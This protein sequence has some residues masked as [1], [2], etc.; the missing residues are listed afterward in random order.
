MEKPLFLQRLFS[1][2]LA[3][4]AT[5]TISFSRR[6]DWH[7]ILG[8]RTEVSLQKCFWSGLSAFARQVICTKT[9]DFPWFPKPSL[10]A[11][12]LRL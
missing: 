12:R 6:K 11:L 9:N 3:F 7:F 4:M 2:S 10:D 8:A 5:C 1:W